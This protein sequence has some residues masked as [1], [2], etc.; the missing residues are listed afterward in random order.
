MRSSLCII[1]KPIKAE[2]PPNTSGGRHHGE[3]AVL[4][5]SAIPRPRLFAERTTINVAQIKTSPPARS[6]DEAAI[7]G[8]LSYIVAPTASTIPAGALTMNA[9]TNCPSWNALGCVSPVSTITRSDGP[10]AASPIPMIRALTFIIISS[11]DPRDCNGETSDSPC[12]SE[13]PGKKRTPRGIA[14][15]GSLS[16]SL[17]SARRASSG[18]TAR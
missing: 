10:I 12:L 7:I 9:S 13:G 14:A 16:M 6:S 2:A 1:F 4:T 3:A 11:I 15:R 5:I 18:S 8:F 17:V